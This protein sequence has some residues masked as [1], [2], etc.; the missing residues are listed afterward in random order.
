MTI[1]LNES[2]VEILAIRA[3]GTGGQN[4]NKVSNAVHLRFDVTASSLPDEVKARLLT[5]R[6]QRV[7]S[8]GVIVIKAQKHR[9]L[10]RN[11]EDG[12]TR[13]RELIAAAAFTPTKRR[14]TKPSRSS[15][16][17]RIDSKVKRGQV[18]L[19]RSRVSE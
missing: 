1:T 19:L 8:D 14:P 2:E 18:K 16:K 7:S 12:L 13:L 11:R 3:Q 9:S 6:D 4:V 10:E 17:K 15:Q 5:M